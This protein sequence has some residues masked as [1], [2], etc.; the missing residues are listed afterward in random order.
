MGA[1]ALLAQLSV[2]T[3]VMQPSERRMR[4]TTP[5]ATAESSQKAPFTTRQLFGGSVEPAPQ[6]AKPQKTRPATL[7]PFFTTA[8]SLALLAGLCYYFVANGGQ[9]R[10]LVWTTCQRRVCS[11]AQNSNSSGNHCC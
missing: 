4:G 3:F 8:V 7:P 5:S 2:V 9:W 6:P 11:K 10:I 1:L